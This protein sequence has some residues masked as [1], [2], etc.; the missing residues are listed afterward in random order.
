MISIAFNILPVR[1]RGI[2]HHRSCCS[3]FCSCYYF[4]CCILASCSRSSR[5]SKNV[6]L[7]GS[8]GGCKS[9]SIFRRFFGLD[10]RK[11]PLSGTSLSRCRLRFWSC[12]CC[13]RQRI[14]VLSIKIKMWNNNI[15]AFIQELIKL[16]CSKSPWNLG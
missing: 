9:I 2:S 12:Y 7:E 11:L 10:S 1:G 6:F 3:C 4:F 13:R 16:E 14:S 15:W 8:M 5:L